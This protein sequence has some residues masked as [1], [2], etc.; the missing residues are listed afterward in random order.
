MNF[1]E[2]GTAFL[3]G[4]GLIL[5]PCILPVLPLILA[6]SVDGGRERPF[7][8]ITGFVLAFSAFV[9]LS[10]KLVMWFG[11]DLDII[12]NASLVLLGAMGLV[13]LSGTL[14]A[15]F[16]ALTQGAANW[17]NRL[18]QNNNGGF[19][20]GLGIGALIGLVWTP[21]AGPFLAAI[22]VQVIRQEKDLNAVTQVVAFALGAGAPMLVIAL[23]GRRIM[24]KLGF[25]TRHAEAVRKGFGIIIL[26]VVVL[27]AFGFDKKLAAIGGAPM[28]TMQVTSADGLYNALPQPYPAPE[29][30]GI[31]SWINSAPLTMASL[32]GKVV[33]V[34]FWT[35]SCINCIRTLPY[36]TAWDAKYKDKG[37][38]I[39]GIH[40]PEFEF[41]KK[42]ENVANAIKQFGIQYPVALDNQLDTWTNFN[43]K[44]WPAHYL[45]NQNGQVVYTHFGEGDYD[46]TENN[47]RHLLGLK[48]QEQ[49]A[50]N[51]L[52]AKTPFEKQTPE[53]YLGYARATHF[54]SAQTA[55]KDLATHFAMPETL[56]FH[57]WALQG[58]WKIEAEKIITS[59]KNASLKIHFI[60]GKVF[61][62]LG[63]ATG[64][65][66]TARITLNG[67]PPGN[68]AGKDAPNGV[69]TIDRHSLYEL[70]SQPNSNEGV[71][72]ITADKPGLEAY[73]FTFG[74]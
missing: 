7:G 62:V 15:K 38:V 13:L 60:A 74:D 9:L 68:V 55:V 24:G 23:M 31:E 12:K 45:I 70:I 35:Y 37:L 48:G 51:V 71:L 54:D 33:L 34:D 17:G 25:F 5:S 30:T 69:V 64:Q 65:P 43:N 28:N 10:R 47:I 50:E 56:N 36:I 6:S 22:L 3:E 66:V 57:H 29:F 14:S 16:N 61:L 44:Y 40:A 11:I 67:K 1:L 18:T 58:K 59:E 39:I 26:V 42:R 20:S 63:T 19:L 41:E 72:E 8:I 4:L 27:I 49:A 32:K 46:V 2:I 73:A 21:C 53:T 52:P